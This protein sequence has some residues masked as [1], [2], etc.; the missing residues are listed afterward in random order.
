VACGLC[1]LRAVYSSPGTAF[2]DLGDDGAGDLESWTRLSVSPQVDSC[3]HHLDA[4]YFVTQ[5]QV[6]VRARQERD[7]SLHSCAWMDLT[8][9]SIEQKEETLEKTQEVKLVRVLA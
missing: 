8:P 5:V 9:S 7:A 6:I 1:K 4:V 2:G 3:T